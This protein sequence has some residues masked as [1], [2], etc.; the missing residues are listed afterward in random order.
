MRPRGRPISEQTVL[1]TGAT[2]GLGRALVHRLT[3]HGA[4]VVAHG[5]SA[6]RLDDLVAEVEH[7]HGVAVDT[8]QADLSSL[9]EV[10]GLADA[11]IA[12]YDALHVLV[13]NAGVGF[14]APGETRQT[15]DDGIEL[16]FAVNHLAAY[17]LSNRLRLLLESSAPA[18]IVQVASAGQ[19]ALDPDD[20]L[21]QRGYAGLDAYRH[22]KL[23]MVMAGYDLAADL[24]G[25]DVTVNSVHPATMMDTEM[26]RA[27]T[28]PSQGTVEEGL[29]ATWRLVADPDLEGVSGRYFDGLDEADPDP[30]AD[31]PAARAWVRQ[32]SETLIGDALT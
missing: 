6:E 3:E 8:V 28:M 17:H 16:R 11:V 24:V 15:S 22:S 19:L 18:R 31:D 26:V 30:Q 23:A 20:P 21:S 2:A 29:E 27:T 13:N 1:V 32:L 4:Q 7:E 25:T 9:T 5:R 10:D 14:G 12:E